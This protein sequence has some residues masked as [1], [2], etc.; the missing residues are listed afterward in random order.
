M[1][2]ELRY[3]GDA[4]NTGFLEFEFFG[5]YVRD[6]ADGISTLNNITTTPNINTDNV[7]FGRTDLLQF[8]STNAN[9]LQSLNIPVGIE[10]V[11]A[12]RN[13]DNGGTG[14]GLGDFIVVNF[15]RLGSNPSDSYT[16]KIICVSIR[17]IYTAYNNGVD[18]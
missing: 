14:S 2:I 5:S 10:Q 16:G 6:V 4:A 12:S 15:G 1:V 9:K 18:F 17:L 7:L 8:D 11:L 13:R 3:F